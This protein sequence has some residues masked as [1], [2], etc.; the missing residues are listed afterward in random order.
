MFNIFQSLIKLCKRQISFWKKNVYS[1]R[2][3]SN[4]KKFNKEIQYKRAVTVT[5]A[6][7]YACVSQ[8]TVQN[9]IS[10]GILPF[11]KLPSRGKGSKRFIMIRLKD[12]KVF[13][14]SNYHESQQQ[15]N[16]KKRE[17]LIL[18]PPDN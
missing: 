14:D 7:Q 15:D 16:T 1:R 13:L 9:W 11:E 3:R 5:E 8:G 10:Q 12:L 18:L 17:E 6:A 2:N 4:R